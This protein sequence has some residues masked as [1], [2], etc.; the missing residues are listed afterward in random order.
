MTQTAVRDRPRCAT[1]TASSPRRAEK[2]RHASAHARSND[3]ASGATPDGCERRTANVNSC[4]EKE[5]FIRESSSVN[6][7]FSGLFEAAFLRDFWHFSRRALAAERHSDWPRIRQF[8]AGSRSS[9]DSNDT[10]CIPLQ[11]I[12]MKKSRA[13][14]S[15]TEIDT[16]PLLVN[17]ATAAK[18]CGRSLRTWR[19]W[20]ATGRTPAPVRIGGSILWRLDEIQAWVEAGCPLRKD[21]PHTAKTHRRMT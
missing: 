9:P 4:I 10:L 17:A 13:G 5:Q 18:L 20:D 2:C 6:K 3:G 21:W 16:R 7:R 12:A 19:S 8:C 14:N 1:S 11:S 15:N